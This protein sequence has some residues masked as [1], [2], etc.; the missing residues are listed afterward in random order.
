[1]T[2][3]FL[4][5]PPVD[6]A[7]LVCKIGDR[8]T[9]YEAALT[10]EGEKVEVGSIYEVADRAQY[11]WILRLVHGSGAAQLRILN[12][13]LLATLTPTALANGSFEDANRGG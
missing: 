4:K 2:N 8:L 10:Q 1:M 12:S 7:S 9:V 6:A 3:P 13:T 5:S 11:A